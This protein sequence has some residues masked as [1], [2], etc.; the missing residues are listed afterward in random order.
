MSF[1]GDGGLVGSPRG[2]IGDDGPGVDGTAAPGGV[3]GVGVG[4]GCCA[5]AAVAKQASSRTLEALIIGRIIIVGGI[6]GLA[7][8]A[9]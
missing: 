8:V 9:C 1:D 2:A 3:A 7:S 6:G 4:C 5:W